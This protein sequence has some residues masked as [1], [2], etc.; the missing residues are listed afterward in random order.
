M[1]ST[2]WSAQDDPEKWDDDPSDSPQAAA[3]H[4]IT[5]DDEDDG[6]H[7]RDDLRRDGETIVTVHGYIE[8]NAP[9]PEDEQFDG[10]VPGCMYYARTG[11]QVK[12]K[13]SLAYGILP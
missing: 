9:L 10:Y 2:H 11:E 5:W 1:K 12:V 3:E 4:C 6:W 7:A 13:V 8:T